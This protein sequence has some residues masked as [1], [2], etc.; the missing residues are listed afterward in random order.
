MT[1]AILCPGQGGQHEAMFD[2]VVEDDAGRATLAAASD[3]A[4]FDLLQTARRGPDLFRNALAQPLICASAVA[5]WAALAPRVPAPSLFLGYSVGELAAHGC[6]GALSAS[7]TIHLACARAAVMDDAYPGL[8]GLIAIRGLSPRAV[9]TLCDE[10]GVEIAIVNG[11]D[12][13]VIGGPDAGLRAAHAS[14]EQ[15]GATVQRLAVSIA[16]HTGLMASAAAGFRKRLSESAIAAPGIA[17]LAGTSGEL[18]T[19]RARAIHALAEQIDHTVQWAR[20]LDAAYERGCRSFLELGP[21]CALAR[22][23]RERF[24][25][26]AAR[27]V[28]EFKTLTGAAAWVERNAAGE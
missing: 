16:P 15:A 19:D 20:C 12:H 4:G 18:V 5:T 26:V 25:E 3:A 13:H 24:P 10:H 6:A 7:E 2:L 17:V 22:M 23:V 28:A 8:A 9:R 1:L 27:S 14:A 11:D 21:R